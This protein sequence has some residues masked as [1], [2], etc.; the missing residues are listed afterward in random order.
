MPK[1][2]IQVFVGGAL[3]AM[4]REYLMLLVPPLKD[5]FPTDILVANLVASLLLGFVTALHA[6]RAV[7]DGAQALI[8]TGIT[9]GMSTFSSYIYG[10]F[11]LMTTPRG[12]T[13]VSL[14]YLIVSLVLGYVAIAVGQRLGARGNRG[15]TIH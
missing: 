15:R 10:A 11:V 8:G 2:V 14:V 4:T 9:G 1:Q 3:G 7:S 13:A 12:S 6:R 5:G